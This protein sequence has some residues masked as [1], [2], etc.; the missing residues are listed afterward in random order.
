[1]QS[2]I[3]GLVFGLLIAGFSQL[4]AQYARH[5]GTYKNYFAGSTLFLLGNFD[6]KN[7]PDLSRLILGI[8]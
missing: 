2:K 8:V 7:S 4:H 1:M 5:D 6:T 3:F